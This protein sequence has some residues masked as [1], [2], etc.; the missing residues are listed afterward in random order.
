MQYL[1]DQVVLIKTCG[2]RE[3]IKLSKRFSVQIHIYSMNYFLVYLDILE[4]CKFIDFFL[5]IS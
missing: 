1:V 4:V 2:I 5:L 3:T